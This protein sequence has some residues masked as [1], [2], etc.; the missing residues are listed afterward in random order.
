[1][2]IEDQQP[3]GDNGEKESQP[4]KPEDSNF[5]IEKRKEISFLAFSEHLL[6]TDKV[7]VSLDR[8]I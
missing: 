6:P 5:P 4:P 8:F 3:I 1:M 2:D 7:L